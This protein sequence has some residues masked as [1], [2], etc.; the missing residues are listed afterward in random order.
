[1]A[2]TFSDAA[3]IPCVNLYT[4]ANSTKLLQAGQIV[5][6]EFQTIA[7]ANNYWVS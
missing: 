2:A 1:M 3:N 6:I 7:A 4:V 5:A